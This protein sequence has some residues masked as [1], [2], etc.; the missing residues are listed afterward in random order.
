VDDPIV[1]V[2][3]SLALFHDLLSKGVP[4]ELHVFEK[5]GH[6]WGLGAP[7]TLVASWPGLFARWC[8]SHGFIPTTS[9]SPAATSDRGTG[10]N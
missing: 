10:D 5:G 7:G 9:S 8:R 6:G 4:A 1:K 2:G 3:A